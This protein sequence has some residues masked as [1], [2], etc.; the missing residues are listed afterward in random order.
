MLR[1]GEQCVDRFLQR[2]T[3]RKRTKFAHHCARN[4]K[5]TR[6]VAHLRERGFLGRADVNEE[7][8]EEEKWIRK[9]TQE[10]E[11][12]RATLADAGRDLCRPSITQARREQ[13]PQNAAAVHRES[14]KQIKEKEDNIY[15]Q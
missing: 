11:N 15:R 8:D 9:Q 14:R 13:R 4:R 1:S 2:R 7:R 5:A 10:S 6:N 3:L 12:K